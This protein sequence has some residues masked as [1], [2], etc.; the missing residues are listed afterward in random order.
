MRPPVI[1]LLVAASLLPVGCSS[2]GSAPTSPST[3]ASTSPEATS[4]QR[5]VARTGPQRVTARVAWALPAARSREVALVTSRGLLVAGGLSAAQVSTDTVWLL[6][7]GDGR[8]L[9]TGRLA[10]A[11]HDAA[12]FT[13]AATSYVVGGGGASTVADVQ[14]LAP[15]A[16]ATVTGRLPQPRSD[17]AAVE[18]GSAGY[19]LAGFDGAR[20]IAAV[21]RTTDGRQFT[22]VAR[23]PVT[24]RYAG[25]VAVGA[26]ILVFGGEHDGVGTT[27]VQEVDLVTHRARVVGHLPLPLS[28]ESAFVLD[29]VVW[30]AGG[31]SAA[32]LQRRIWRWDPTTLRLRPAGSLPYAVADAGI[33]VAGPV[34][35]LLGGE[36]P[37]PLRSVVAIRPAP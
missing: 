6:R 13:L 36:A 28:H 33:A 14:R 18:T 17:L 5:T 29:G 8:V 24:V 7:P 34:A 11:V 1:A 12:G 15:G 20:S 2:T 19:V 26:R 23:L 27:D 16:T 32:V 9:S 30:L 21:L 10:A 3:S 31:R 4:A 37:T 25:V 35:Y 22:T